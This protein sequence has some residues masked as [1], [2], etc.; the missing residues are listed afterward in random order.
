LPAVKWKADAMNSD[1]IK[2]PEAVDFLR[3][4]SEE[5]GTGNVEGRLTA[6]SKE[7]LDE[8]DGPTPS[9]QESVPRLQRR[10]DL[11]TAMTQ[12]LEQS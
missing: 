1:D 3:G 7:L 5:R 12:R 11:L 8:V 9:G 6:L 2:Q 10:Y 4:R